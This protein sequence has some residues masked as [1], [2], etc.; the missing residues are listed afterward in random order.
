MLT[1]ILFVVTVA[2]S[3]T[4]CTDTNEYTTSP[5][6]CYHGKIKSSDF[7]RSGFKSDVKLWMT[8]DVDSLAQGI[9]GNT[10]LTTSDGAFMDAPVLQMPQ[11]QHDS[12]SLFSFPG[13]QVR[14][15]LGYAK[16]SEGLPATVVISLMEHGD[17]E[18][19]L[20]RPDLD[21]DDDDHSLFA[22]FRLVL[23]DGCSVE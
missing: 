6:E 5:G 21:D 20:M 4:A 17:V 8:L 16:P 3:L 10:K 15:Y 7:I 23:Q 11:L 12:L 13:G 18:V 14:S 19:R 9:A 2:L 22:V 1:K